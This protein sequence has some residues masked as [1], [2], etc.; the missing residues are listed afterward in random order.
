MN[1]LLAFALVWI[2]IL[3]VI[4]LDLYFNSPWDAD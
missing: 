2:F 3:S 4:G 1:D